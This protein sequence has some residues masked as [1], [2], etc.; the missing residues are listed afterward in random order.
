MATAT[1]DAPPT[2]ETLAD[3]LDH[4]GGIPP[5]RVR[6]V[7]APGT[8][9]EADLF[10]LSAKSDRSF[11]LIDG[12]LVEKRMAFDSGFLA[13]TIAM[14]LRGFVDP[15]NLGL[16]NGADASLRLFPGLVR[17]PDVS[18]VSWSRIPGGR[19]PKEPIPDLVPD[20]AVEVLSPSNTAREMTLKR[21]HYFEAGVRLVWI[22]DP[23]R[24]AV[25][26]Y[27]G[28]DRPTRLGASAKLDGGDVLPGFA[29]PPSR[30]FADLDRRAPG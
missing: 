20:L 23:R 15:R 13:L 4:L 16:V 28:P 6:L 1:I 29:L 11:E 3:V 27:T 9:T 10:A 19:M 24:R 2:F 7:P 22:V 25:A 14:V 18:Y 5:E 17:I 8:A 21:R 12:I 30:F 26:V